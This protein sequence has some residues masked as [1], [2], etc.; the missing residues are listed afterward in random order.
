MGDGTCPAR[1][2]AARPGV[3]TLGDVH[4]RPLFLLPAILAAATLFAA[5]AGLASHSSAPAADP[6]VRIVGATPPA[7]VRP[8][9]P[10][11]TK[12]VSIAFTQRLLAAGESFTAFAGMFEP[13]EP[14]AIWDFYADDRKVAWLGSSTAAADGLLELVRDLAVGTPA[15]AHTLCGQ[16]GRTGAV[17]CARYAVRATA[18]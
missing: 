14:V 17:A 2:I 9:A 6:A 16:G 7:G 18:G 5:G 1:G 3:H 13:G 15:G 8:P 4:L 12:G 10:L 11:S